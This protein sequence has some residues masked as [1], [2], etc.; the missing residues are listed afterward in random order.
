MIILALDPAHSTG[1]ALAKLENNHCEI[2]EYGFLDV[3]NTSEYTG[4]W[5][6]DLMSQVQKL[7]DKHHFDEVGVEDY[8][9]SARFV[10]GANVNPMYR[11]A[12]HIWCRQNKIHYSILNISNWKVFVAGR[13]TPTKPQKLKWGK[14][15]AKKKMTIAALRDRWNI[16]LPDYSISTKTGKPIKFRFDIGDAIGQVMYHVYE[17]YNCTNFS[18]SV[19]L[20]PKVKGFESDI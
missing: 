3:A 10:Q 16:L 17:R 2:Y 4:D 7:Y 8:F 20:P 15:A 13:S 6:L 18:C 14:E 1:Y 19:A 11:A 12:I 9:F 5:C